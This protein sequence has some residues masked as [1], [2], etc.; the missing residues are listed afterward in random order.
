MLYIK[1]IFISVVDVDGVHFDLLIAEQPSLF[2]AIHEFLKISERNL[3]ALLVTY[4][5]AD[6]CIRTCL[7]E[8]GKQDHTIS[9][10]EI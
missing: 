5:N 8:L 4:K 1:D 10:F 2:I 6:L 7:E 3:S 9:I